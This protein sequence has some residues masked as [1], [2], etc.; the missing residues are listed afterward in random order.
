M[1][2]IRDRFVNKAAEHFSPTDLKEE[3]KSKSC[4][5]CVV[6]SKSHSSEPH[7]RRAFSL[8]QCTYFVDLCLPISHLPSF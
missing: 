6:S 1:V 3:M 2:R 8:L 4:V 5:F 7:F